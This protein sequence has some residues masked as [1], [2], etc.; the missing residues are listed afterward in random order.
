MKKREKEKLHN[1]ATNLYNI[2][3]EDYYNKYHKLSDAK[4]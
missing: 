1:S 4:K 3:F 2:R